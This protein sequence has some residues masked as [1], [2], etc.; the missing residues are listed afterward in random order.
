MLGHRDGQVGHRPPRPQALPGRTPPR[1]AIV[2]RDVHKAVGAK[3][4]GKRDDIT[5]VRLAI[6]GAD[7]LLPLRLQR[8]PLAPVARSRLLYRL[9]VIRREDQPFA[10]G[11]VV[12]RQLAREALGSATLACQIISTGLTHEP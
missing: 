1:P 5:F 10:H 2:H 6:A 3:A 4:G 12:R 8:S 7:T 9:I 11:L